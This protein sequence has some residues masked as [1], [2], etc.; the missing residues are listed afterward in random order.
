[1]DLS[2]VDS[3]VIKSLI[4]ALKDSKKVCSRR[5]SAQASAEGNH[6]GMGLHVLNFVRLHNKAELSSQVTTLLQTP[7]LSRLTVHCKMLEFGPQYLTSFYNTL[8]LSVPGLQ[9]FVMEGNGEAFPHLGLSLDLVARCLELPNL[10]SL[11]CNFEP[12]EFDEE[13]DLHGTEWEE[14][15]ALTLERL[16]GRL[17][18]QKSNQLRKL[19]LPC[20]IWPPDFLVPFFEDC[21]LDLE[22][23]S[24]PLFHDFPEGC[25]YK[26]DDLRE[27]LRSSCPNIKKIA[28]PKHS[29]G[30]EWDYYATL[31]VKTVLE[32]C[33][34]TNGTGAGTSLQSL[35][36]AS[37][38]LDWTQI[39]PLLE[40]HIQNLRE[41][42]SNGDREQFAELDQLV[43]RSKN[44][45]VLDMEWHFRTSGYPFERWPDIWICQG[46]RKLNV[47]MAI[48]AHRTSPAPSDEVGMLSRHHLKQFYKAIEQLEAL[49]DLTLDYGFSY[50][51][52][53]IWIT[54]LLLP[55]NEVE[56]YLS[57]LTRWKK[58]RHLR[59][60][61]DFWSRMG[62]PE[63]KFMAK[64]WPQ[65]ESITFRTDDVPW[66]E[67]FLNIMHCWQTLVRLLPNLV[68]K[69][70]KS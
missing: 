33:T 14:L 2:D 68:F 35:V 44:L 47:R 40:P 28:I 22:E 8:T 41:L 25:E 20:M 55:T 58:L 1:M 39:G 52:D 69:C 56:G 13:Q 62:D 9:H 26:I 65:L 36:A 43:R 16:E 37:S 21:G 70:L 42:T 31:A 3:R 48:P 66:M 24:V 60:R 15:F 4:D 23:L 6:V 45:K 29:R 34:P 54:D 63:I 19:Q 61:S 51:R 30:Y 50:T 12:S 27:V 67:K 10:V 38:S 11:V 32:A 18:H 46:L 59:L 53:D 17:P 49:E 57:D 64:H 7:F 5:Q